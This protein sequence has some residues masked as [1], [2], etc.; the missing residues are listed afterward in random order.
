[1]SRKDDTED[2][3]YKR[4]VSLCAEDYIILTVIIICLV[5]PVLMLGATQIYNI[6]FPPVVISVFLGIAVA[7]LLYRFLGGTQGATFAIGALKVTGS[8]AILAGISWWTDSRLENQLSIYNNKTETL[9]ELNSTKQKLDSKNKYIF[10]LKEEI[11]E[12]KSEK[13]QETHK[14]NTTKLE[15]TQLKS[16]NHIPNFVRNLEPEDDVSE[17][18]RDIQ[19]E[20]EGPWRQFSKSFTLMVSVVDYLPEGSVAACEEN[21]DKKLEI[22]SDFTLNGQVVRTKRPIIMDV[23]HYIRRGK[24]CKDKYKYQLQINCLDAAKIFTNKVLSCGEGKIA[25][26]NVDAQFLPVNVVSLYE[27]IENP[28][29]VN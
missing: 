8:A 27:E 16:G 17:I 26:W 7:S 23:K 22:I 19:Y 13:D 18:L 6:P 3:T 15:L 24:D 25:K 12:L 9:N 5:S 20:K 11:R 2:H 10:E 29:K 28:S 21:I 1:M 14:Y 4:K